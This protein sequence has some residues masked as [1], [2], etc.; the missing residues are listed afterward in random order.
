MPS[1]VEQI[2]IDSSNLR[3]TLVES[4]N[5]VTRGDLYDQDQQLIKFH[6]IYQ[7]DDRDKRAVLKAAKLGKAFSFMLRVRMPGGVASPKQWLAIDELST[8]F[9][10]ETIKLTTRQA[11]QL[12]G[13]IKK[14]LKSTVQEINKVAL[15]TIAACGDVNR[16][17]MSNPNRYLSQAHLEAIEL[18]EKISLHLLPKTRAYHEIWLDGQKLIDSGV[19]EEP[20][21][22]KTYL[23]RKF[24]I[25][26]AVPPSNDVDAYAQDLAFVS[27]VEDG[28]AVGY[29]VLV[30]GGMG[31]NHGNK[32]TFARV[33][34]VLGICRP[35]QVVQVAEEV[36]KIQR[37]FGDRENR[38]HAR[39]KYTIAD[40]S[41]AWFREELETRLGYK[42]AEPQVIN[43][44][45]NGDSYGWSVDP[46]GYSH[47]NLYVEGGRVIDRPNHKIRSGLAAIAREHDGE[48]L[49]TPN[50]NLIIA[51]ISPAKRERIAQ[52]IE[53]YHLDDLRLRS[54]LRL[55]ALSCVSL[56]TCSLALAEAERFLPEVLTQ[57]EESLEE[58]GLRHDAITIR[59]TGCPNGCA[60]PFLGEI[61][62]VGK[63]PNKYNVYFGGSHN[64]SR[65][66]KLVHESVPGGELAGKIKP[67][68]QA[69]A[70][71]REN[72]ER[73][74]DWYVRT[75]SVAE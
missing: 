36:V 9:G 33:A 40:R 71:T 25:G 2:K 21:Y 60:R 52:L 50:Q 68:L 17:V 43:F 6:G 22:G 48:F 42:L 10:N 32:A 55:S 54:G 13:V 18:A 3:G 11:F 27:V 5:D 66:N 47:F 73:F 8:R 63:A 74:G 38:K 31:M 34:D 12:H 30:G 37:D 72:G 7:Q 69:Y 62:F 56:P 64:G 59:M 58:Y 19:E 1:E 67:L 39:L 16:N 57:L 46:D 14:N 35:D 4:L 24:K 75:Q 51:R 26:I 53:E 29:H 28:K 49:L 15:D 20:I 41:A 61:A 23:P 44:K 70:Q 65:L 45:D